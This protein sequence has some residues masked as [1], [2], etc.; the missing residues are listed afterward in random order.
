VSRGDHGWR[1][2]C[3]VWRKGCAHPF[4]GRAGCGDTEKY[5]DPEAMAMTRATRRALRNAFS[6]ALRVES[7]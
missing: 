5:D 7:E 3:H 2:T 1:A 4:E 6:A